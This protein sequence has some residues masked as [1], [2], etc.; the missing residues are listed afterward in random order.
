[1]HPVGTRIERD[2]VTRTQ[3][4]ASSTLLDRPVLGACVRA[5][6]QLASESVPAV[7]RVM[8]DM[9]DDADLKPS[10]G[11]RGDGASCRVSH[12]MDVSVDLANSSHY[13]VNDASQGFSIWTED[14]PGTTTDWYFVLP[15]VFGKK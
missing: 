4:V 6:A 14:E 10:G 3:Y 5:A 7:L 11:M 9:E 2:L 13:D 15:N 12:T 1:M 8:Q